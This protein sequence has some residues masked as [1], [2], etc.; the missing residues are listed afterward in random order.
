[1]VKITF[2]FL[3]R[4]AFTMFIKTN[5]MFIKHLIIDSQLYVH[6]NRILNDN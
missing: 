2:L 5:M 1:M 6:L 3:L 4:M